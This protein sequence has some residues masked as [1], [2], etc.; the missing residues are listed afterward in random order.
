MIRGFFLSEEKYVK[1]VGV[2][3]KRTPNT[4]LS[5]VFDLCKTSGEAV[6]I[7]IAGQEDLL[8]NRQIKSLP[9]VEQLGS[10]FNPYFF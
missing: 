4:S 7:E 6:F 9:V 5:H 3:D 2:T 10:P 1:Q 8:R